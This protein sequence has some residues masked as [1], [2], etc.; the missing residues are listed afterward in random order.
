MNHQIKYTN[1]R[2]PSKLLKIEDVINIFLWY[3][4]YG[5]SKVIPRLGSIA[6]KMILLVLLF[7]A[8][9]INPSLSD[10]YN[11]I[12][13]I[14]KPDDPH[15]TTMDL[16]ELTH[17]LFKNFNAFTGLINLESVPRMFT[18]NVVQS[19]SSSPTVIHVITLLSAQA[20]AS[21]PRTSFTRTSR[22]FS[23]SSTRWA[24]T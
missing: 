22:Y 7:L 3:L 15:H 16:F 17:N 11:N 19:L 10:Y 13:A 6:P 2:A 9:Y 14:Q 18:T 23:S 5:Q 21:L 1:C 24:G 8:C 12:N 4:T 20:S